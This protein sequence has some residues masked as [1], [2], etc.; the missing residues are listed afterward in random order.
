VFHH[1][2]KSSG[3]FPAVLYEVISKRSSVIESSLSVDDLNHILDDLAQNMGKQYVMDTLGGMRP[4]LTFRDVQSKILQRIYN[5]STA[6]EQR[7][8]I[9]IIL[10]GK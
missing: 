10:K 1:E 9:R 3:D 7:W 2:Q 5:K 8:I 4:H 6:E